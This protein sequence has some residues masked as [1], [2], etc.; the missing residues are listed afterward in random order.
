MQRAWRSSVRGEM[1]ALDARRPRGE[2]ES[3]WLKTK[4][5]RGAGFLY[6]RK[7]DKFVRETVY[8]A[9]PPMAS[10]DVE[11]ICTRLLDLLI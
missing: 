8:V 5:G 10:H 9:P 6:T 4:G 7:D 1:S 11:H 2:Y 3:C